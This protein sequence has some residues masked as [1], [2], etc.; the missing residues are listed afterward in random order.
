MKVPAYGV[1]YATFEATADFT[2]DGTIEVYLH[3]TR[4]YPP[5]TGWTAASWAGPETVAGTVR[6]RSFT[7]LLAG[8]L[9]NPLPS[10]A[11][12]LVLGQNYAFVRLTDS[13]EVIIRPAGKVEGL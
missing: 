6:T 2:L 7:V 3:D 11:Q 12:Q 1:E 13:P 8:R 10:G 5:S 9:V 4:E